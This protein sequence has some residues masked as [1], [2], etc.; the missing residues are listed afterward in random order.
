[1]G[2]TAGGGTTS[3]AGSAAAG[4][5]TT[6]GGTAAGSTAGS[7]A[8]SSTPPAQFAEGTAGYSAWSIF[9]RYSSNL[10][11]T[12]AQ[13]YT[14]VSGDQMRLISERF[15]GN[16]LYYPLIL[17]ANRDQVVDPA[18]INVGMVLTIPDLN[19]NLNNPASLQ[20]IKETYR[21]VAALRRA[22]GSTAEADSL[23][24]FGNGL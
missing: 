8:I 15:Y 24:A 12:N 2:G 6:A 10:I 4:S 18:L 22:E 23:L 3:T 7:G 11:L 16:Q 19:A 1:S 21:D 17:L 14:V 9:N 13:Q 5:G 20:S